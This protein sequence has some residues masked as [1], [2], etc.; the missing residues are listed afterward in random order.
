MTGDDELAD[1]L[2]VLVLNHVGQVFC[3][4]AEDAS[5]GRMQ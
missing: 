3:A 4:T 5:K 2:S 1:R